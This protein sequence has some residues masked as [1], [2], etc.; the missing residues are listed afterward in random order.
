V[1]VDSVE[2]VGTACS[3]DVGLGTGVGVPVAD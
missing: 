2:E 3:L 1:A